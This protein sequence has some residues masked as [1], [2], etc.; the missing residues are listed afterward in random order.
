[1]VVFR[2]LQRGEAARLAPYLDKEL[3]AAVLVFSVMALMLASHR[4]SRV[5]VAAVEALRCVQNPLALAGSNDLPLS[6]EHEDGPLG[7]VWLRLLRMA[8]A[9]AVLE[10]VWLPDKVWAPDMTMMAV[11]LVEV[12]LYPW[13]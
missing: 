10:Q 3:S 4:D 12:V 1:V 13:C 7:A 5:L 2:P 9:L 8:L 6:T 11:G